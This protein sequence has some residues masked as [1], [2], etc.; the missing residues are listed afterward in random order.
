MFFRGA[1]RMARSFARDVN[2]E[3]SMGGNSLRAAAQMFGPNM[4]FQGA[5][6]AQPMFQMAGQNDPGNAAY[7]V[8]NFTHSVAAALGPMTGFTSN[9]INAV[10]AVHG[11]TSALTD[12]Q[13]G[14][15]K[16]SG[17]MSLSLA[18]L[19]TARMFRDI[20]MAK[21]TAK[22]FTDL[23]ASLDRLEQA[24]HPWQKA[25]QNAINWGTSKVAGI[26][27]S[28]MNA[29]TVPGD[30]DFDGTPMSLRDRINAIPLAL[31]N[32]LMAALQG[33]SLPNAKQANA[34]NALQQMFDMQLAKHQ[35]NSARAPRPGIPRRLHDGT[36]QR[37]LQTAA[38]IGGIFPIQN[39][40]RNP[41]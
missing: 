11:W 32:H 41:P 14:V 5:S 40:K 23:T 24:I 3:G 6:Y 1:R 7:T 17:P 4:N 26:T 20:D 37:L 33:R 39:N 28:F 2:Y 25:F 31:M 34:T 18:K 36:K 29:F 38:N 9:L 30:R 15:A 12:S 8:N 10:R 19:D 35:I 27:A 21:G 22:T 16:Y 13:R